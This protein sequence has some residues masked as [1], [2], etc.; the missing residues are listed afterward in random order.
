MSS[1]SGALEGIERVLNRGG[2]ADD[3]RP[4]EIRTGITDGRFTQVTHGGDR[5]RRRLVI[6]LVRRGDSTLFIPLSRKG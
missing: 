6:L 3:P 2:E 5:P 4:V 1:H